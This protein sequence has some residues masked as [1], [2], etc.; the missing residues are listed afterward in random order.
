MSFMFICP[1]C[2]NIKDFRTEGDTQF[3]E[4]VCPNCIRERRRHVREILNSHS[5]MRKVRKGGHEGKVQHP[6]KGRHRVGSAL[7]EVRRKG[8][9]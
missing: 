6:H 9:T 3:F 2:G 5:T 4:E 1:L 7:R 8:G